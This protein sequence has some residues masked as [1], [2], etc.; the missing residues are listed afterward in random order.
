MDLE[1]RILATAGADREPGSGQGFAGLLVD[2]AREPS[3]PVRLVARAEREG[4]TGLLAQALILTGTLDRLP[5]VADTLQASYRRIARDNLRRTGALQELLGACAESGVPVVLLKGMAL[6]QD[7]YYDPGTRDMTDIDLWIRPGDESVVNGRLD[8]LGY[9]RDPLY[10]RTRRRGA[11]IFDLHTHYL[12]ADRIRARRFLLEREEEEVFAA[13]RR[14]SVGDHPARLLDPP[15]RV[16]FLTLHTLKHNV[17]KLIWLVDIRRLT[18]G[19]EEADWRDFF[20]RVGTEGREKAVARIL[21][22]SRELLAIAHPEIVD[23]WLEGVGVGPRGRNLLARRS[24]RGSLPSWAPLLFLLPPRGDLRRLRYVGETLFPRPDV[25]RQSFPDRSARP[26]WILYL[27][28]AVQV[29][30][31][32]FSAVAALIRAPLPGRERSRP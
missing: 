19:W 6:L 30:G 20:D 17:G 29:S 21:I 18:L 7:T 22:L 15:D 8:E 25:L 4:L 11:V 16:L 32:L 9:E 14:I 28:R 24:T 13:C 31:W 27:L 10:P 2:L 12:G 5:A 23:R 26:A 1:S 3:A